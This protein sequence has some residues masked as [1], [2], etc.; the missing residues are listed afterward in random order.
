[1]RHIAKNE[2]GSNVLERWQSN[3][4]CPEN[5]EQATEQWNRFG[6]K[7]VVRNKLLTQQYDLCAYTQ[8]QITEFCHVAN[9]KQGCH[10]E[11]VKPKA[12]SPALTFDY[13][14]LLVS[15]LSGDDLGLPILEHRYFAG[16]YR[17]NNQYIE[18]LFIT[19][20]EADCPR[21]FCYLE[22][23]GEIVPAGDLSDFDKQRAEFT[24][25]HLNLN[26]PFLCNQRFKRMQ[27]VIEDIEFEENQSLI[28]DIIAKEVEIID[29]KM[30]SF[31]SAVMALV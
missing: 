30:A 3:N 12:L 14:N 24:I 20:L 1:M 4:P 11:H 6:K 21:Y 25:K 9:S 19:P 2:L 10:I 8:M 22:E 18:S 15:I 28:V 31:P 26:H 27:E 5:S 16:H 7:T 17:D 29:G 13:H 23:T